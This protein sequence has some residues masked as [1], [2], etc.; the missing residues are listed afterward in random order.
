MMLESKVNDL[1]EING[2]WVREAK[3]L[4]QRQRR[5]DE[6]Q[7]YL[8]KEKAELIAGLMEDWSR[9]ELESAGILPKIPKGKRVK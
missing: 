3:M 8:D 2:I 1:P 5:I 9:E 7:C 4:D 6:D